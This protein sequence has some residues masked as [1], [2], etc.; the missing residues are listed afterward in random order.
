MSFSPFSSE[1]KPRA[2]QKQPSAS[3]NNLIILAEIEWLVV[4]IDQSRAPL[5]I[6]P[7]EQL[8]ALQV[9]LMTIT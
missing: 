2:A 4:E 9:V 7:F 8:H 3:L 6:S 1:R 5:L